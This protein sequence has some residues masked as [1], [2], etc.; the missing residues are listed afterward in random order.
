MSAGLEQ[1]LWEIQA[2]LLENEGQTDIGLFLLK[3]FSFIVT[4]LR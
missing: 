1:T 4:L 2:V 3:K